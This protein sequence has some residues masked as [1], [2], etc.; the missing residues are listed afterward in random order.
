MNSNLSDP[1][2]WSRLQFA[3]T[4]TYHYLFPQLTMGVAWFLVYWKWRAL[5]TGNE[6]Y[7]QAVR[8][9]AKIFGLNFAVGVVTGIPMEFQFGTNWA[10]FSRYAGGV[11]GQ[12]L[13]MEGMF[14]FF[15]E[16]AFVGV[17]IWGEKRLGPRYHFMAALAVALG[18]WI[19]GY[20][21][22]VTN[23]FMQHPVGY[24]IEA[25][26]SLGI[27][28]LSAYLLNPWA[29]VQ[30]AHNQLAALVTGSFVVTAV[31]ALYTLR[32]LHPIQA[33]LY[34][35]AGTFIA[36]IASALVAFPTGD[37]QAKMVGNHQPVTLAAMEGRFVGGPMAGVAV[38][39]QPNIAARR[40]DNPIEVP[41]ALSFLAYGHFGS[42]VH[43]LEEYSED[44]WPDNIELLYYS[45][46]LMI[47]LG[48]IFIIL[49]V[50]ASFQN[51]RDRL[52]SSTWLLWVLMLAFPFP[53]IANTLGWM[54]AELGRQPWLIY[55]LFRTRDGVSKVV[56][57][58]DTIFTL[59]GFIGL[60]FVL[61]LL[62]LFLVGRE[63]GHGPDEEVIASRGEEPSL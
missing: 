53:Y 60:Y 54:T 10:D 13:A 30:F 20:F 9:W 45:F 51:W 56:S 57:N 29:W 26:G 48:T 49:M 19:S 1:A 18:S 21:I 5:R 50:Y 63:I 32:G 4:L 15:L 28:S 38:I 24:R 3:F 33:R 8:F 34:L 22:L 31:G 37:Q 11:I 6:K 16:S 46:H 62:F 23:A 17:L 61:G 58:G 40:L 14:A 42:Y 44:T 59:I 27:A 12:T 2:F 41:G 39:G 25:D 35:R 43:G 47:T 55:G 7:N 36:L 52:E